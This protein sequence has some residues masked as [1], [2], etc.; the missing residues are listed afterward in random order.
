ME[1]GLIVV[2]PEAYLV[3]DLVAK[4]VEDY[5]LS[6]DRR[7]KQKWTREKIRQTYPKKNF[8]NW[9]MA[10]FM[11]NIIFGK[12]GYEPWIEAMIVS[13]E[14]D[15][16]KKVKK[17][18]GPLDASYAQRP[19]DSGTLRYKYGIKE[20]R[21]MIIDGK[22]YY[23]YFNGVHSSTKEDLEREIKIYTQD[24]TV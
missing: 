17:L 20:R 9:P 21:I 16:V 12:A 4:D 5:G 11:D 24:I 18:V 15:T 6:I 8:P 1:N 3:K 7:I 23:F 13:S 22:P 2:K 14:K 10:E 19:E